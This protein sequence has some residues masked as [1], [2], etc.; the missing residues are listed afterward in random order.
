M[1][2][3]FLSATQFFHVCLHREDCSS[4]LL[5]LLPRHLRSQRWKALRV[6]LYSNIFIVISVDVFYCSLK[7]AFTVVTA[8]S[9]NCLHLHDLSNDSPRLKRNGRLYSFVWCLESDTFLFLAHLC[10]TFLSV[11]VTGKYLNFLKIS[12]HAKC[13]FLSWKYFYKPKE[14]TK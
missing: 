5:S 4:M 2:I 6:W 11:Q 13:A 14:K 9:R 12:D 10:A 8:L 3:G 7:K 1:D